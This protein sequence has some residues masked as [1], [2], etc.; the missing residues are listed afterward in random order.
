MRSG[1]SSVESFEDLG[2]YARSQLRL[3]QGWLFGDRSIRASLDKFMSQLEM[4]SRLTALEFLNWMYLAHRIPIVLACALANGT[5][6]P[7]PDQRWAGG[8]AKDAPS[9]GVTWGKMAD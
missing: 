9:G 2:P 1:I 8:W 4:G 6:I 7:N 5:R 3:S